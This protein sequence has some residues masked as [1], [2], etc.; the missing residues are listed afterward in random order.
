MTINFENISAEVAGIKLSEAQQIELEAF[1]Q[2]TA[3]DFKPL[4]DTARV[5]LNDSVEILKEEYL[6]KHQGKFTE[7]QW[8]EIKDILHIEEVKP[9]APGLESTSQTTTTP[10]PGSTPQKTTP[11]PG[12]G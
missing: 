5:I 1:K 4:G 2:N 3:E 8:E 12:G 11:T 9:S 6:T 7:A 10:T